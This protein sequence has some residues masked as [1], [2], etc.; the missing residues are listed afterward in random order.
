MTIRKGPRVVVRRSSFSHSKSCVDGFIASHP[1]NSALQI[2]L[3]KIYR[4]EESKS[5]SEGLTVTEHINVPTSPGDLGEVV[6]QHRTQSAQQLVEKHVNDCTYT[7]IRCNVAVLLD[8]EFIERHVRGQYAQFCALSVNT[9]LDRTDAAAIL[10]NGHL[11]L[12][13]RRSTHTRLGLVGQH[14]SHD[15]GSFT[16]DPQCS[17]SVL[18]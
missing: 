9:H 11:V 10:P 17:E 5:L 14:A 18:L 13:V 4:Q 2:C 3:P 7:L 12:S 15:P 1:F 16:A 6:D 8:T